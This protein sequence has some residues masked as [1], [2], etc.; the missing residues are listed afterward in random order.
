MKKYCTAD[1]VNMREYYGISIQDRM[2][3]WAFKKRIRTMVNL[4]LKHNVKTDHVLDIGAGAFFMAFLLIKNFN[5]RYIGVDI[6][7]LSQMKKYREIMEVA[8]G[9]KIEVIRASATS[10]PFKE[11]LFETTF[12]LDILE[13]LEKPELAWQEINRVTQGKIMVS[14]PLENTL[15][16][17]I[18]LP[19]LLSE[20]TIRDPTPSFH[21]IGHFKLYIE[22]WV[23]I[24]K[25]QCIARKYSPLG[26]PP[27]LNFYAIHLCETNHKSR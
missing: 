24:L 22:L 10:L 1:D 2:R 15:Q 12:A 19:V 8:I 26:G 20:G 13:H 11:S 23:K 4:I 14:L 5:S 25:K 17:I 16:K 6:L 27:I 7:S 9:K 21:Y 3:T 18:R